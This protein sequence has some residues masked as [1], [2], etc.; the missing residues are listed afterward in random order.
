VVSFYHKVTGLFHA[1]H[2]MSADP[3]SIVLNTPH[4]HIAMDGDHF[5]RLSHRADVKTGKVVDEMRAHASPDHGCNAADRACHLNPE[6]VAKEETRRHA[7]LRIK[8][9]EL[10]GLRS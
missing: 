2:L 10:A 4:D 6:M 9:L 1:R 3:K 8:Q 7:I 5:D